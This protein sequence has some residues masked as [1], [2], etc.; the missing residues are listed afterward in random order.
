MRFLSIPARQTRLT[1]PA[2]RDRA[3]GAAAGQGGG[4]AGR[5]GGGRGAASPSPAGCPRHPPHCYV[6]MT[7]YQ[8]ISMQIKTNKTITV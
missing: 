4:R 2:D 3:A 7:K 8:Y 1:P 5:A 6:I